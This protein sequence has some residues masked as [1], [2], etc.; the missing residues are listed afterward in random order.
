MT[1]VVVIAVLA[2]VA[3]VIINSQRR[4][5]VNW[6][7]VGGVVG[8]AAVFVA[9]FLLFDPYRAETVI[10]GAANAGDS[11]GSPRMI[12]RPAGDG[13]PRLEALEGGVVPLFFC[14]RADSVAP[15]GYWMHREGE[16]G[17]PL[18]EEMVSRTDTARTAIRRTTS[19]F[20]I[21]RHPARAADYLPICRL[22]MPS[23]EKVLAVMPAYDARPG[24]TP[25]GTARPLEGK[26]A[27]IAEQTPGVNANVYVAFFDTRR[28]RGSKALMAA[29]SA[30][31]ATAVAAVAGAAGWAA[32]KI[33]R[34][35][36]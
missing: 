2:V 16:G 34:K 6:L 30:L 3:R 31:F 7:K 13:V 14:L 1:A 26:M 15:T 23:G 33:V 5:G 22:T 35:K 8:L 4:G 21:T 32:V 18:R 24:E 11:S 10:L 19:V 36:R 29:Y 20:G 25:V 27:Q 12:G 17:A 28:H 9:A